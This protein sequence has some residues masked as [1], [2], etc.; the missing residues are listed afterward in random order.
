[1]E[2]TESYYKLK[3]A[4]TS[5]KTSLVIENNEIHKI[6]FNSNS[7][8]LLYGSENHQC[9][10]HQIQ[11]PN[12]FTHT[13]NVGT[14]E[15]D[16]HIKDVFVEENK[17]FNFYILK[18]KSETPVKKVIFMFHGFNEKSWDKYLPWGKALCN[19]TKSAIIFFPLAFHMQ[20]APLAWSEKRKMFELSQE[21]KNIFPNI[22]N[23]T[24]SNVAI[25]MR[26][27]AIPQRFIWSGVQTYNDVIQFI[28]ECKNGNH[29]LIDKDFTYDMFA[30]SIGGLLA[31]ILKLSNYKNYF[32]NSKVALFCSGA[33][34]NRITP[35]SKFIIDSE[36]I[37]ALYSYLVEHF[38]SFLKKD[39]MLNHFIKENHFE[40]KVFHAMFEYQKMMIFREELLRKYENQIYAIALRGDKVIPSYEVVNTLQ[41]ASRNIN[42]KV[43]ELDFDYEYSHENPF[44]LIKSN[45]I[46]IEKSFKDVFRKIGDFYN[47]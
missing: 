24:L 7:H 23:S 40:G 30:Y 38:D 22:I 11:F 1:M 14:I 46:N 43:D 4:F 15:D 31:E 3:E 44:P 41:G 29:Q 16:V 20:R 13:N 21:R 32:S 35:V 42:I 27:H 10:T 36:A 5:V 45:N 18:P 33:V 6:E 8:H 26:L 34:F 28:E 37:V 9:K 12:H 25:S 19:N 47:S 17:K 2:Y 39:A